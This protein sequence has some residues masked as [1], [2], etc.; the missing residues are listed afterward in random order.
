MERLRAVQLNAR[1]LGERD[2]DV[3]DV[4][5]RMTQGMRPTELSAARLPWH[6]G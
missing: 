2:V 6:Q 4:E 1:P 3:D 5:H